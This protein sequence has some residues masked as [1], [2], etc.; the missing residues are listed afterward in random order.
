MAGTP[1]KRWLMLSAKWQ[2]PALPSPSAKQ[3]SLPRRNAVVCDCYR[4]PNARAGADAKTNPMPGGDGSA[5]T[6]SAVT[7]L[8]MSPIIGCGGYSWS[9]KVS[10]SRCTCTLPL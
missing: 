7:C 10:S 1:A 9:R 2:S 8:Q 3:L 4:E 6:G 5:R